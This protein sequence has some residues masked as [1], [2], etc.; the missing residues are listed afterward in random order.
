V[1]Q[2]YRLLSIFVTTVFNK[3]LIFGVRRLTGSE[4]LHVRAF[5]DADGSIYLFHPYSIG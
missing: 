1:I 4:V 3:S 5:Y 2:G